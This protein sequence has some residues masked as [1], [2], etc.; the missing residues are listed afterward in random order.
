MHSYAHL[1]LPADSFLF[2]VLAQFPGVACFFV[3]SGFLVSESCLKST[4]GEFFF[5]RAL[6]IYPAL[7]VN[8]IVLEFLLW[9]SGSVV[10]SP[11]TYA[12][13]LPV[14]ILTASEH[15]GISASGGPIYAP[16]QFFT[17]YPSGVLWTLTVELSFYLILPLVLLPVKQIGRS[18]GTAILA[19][20]AAGSFAMAHSADAAFYAS[21]PKLNITIAPYFW[22]FALGVIVRLWWDSL[23]KFFVGRAFWWLAGY[24][25]LTVTAINMGADSW[26]DYKLGPGFD[27][28]SRLVVMGCATLSC[29]YTLPSLAQRLGLA[30]NDYSYGLYLW[31]MLVVATLIALGF[32]GQWWLWPVVYAGGL[33]LAATS[34]HVIERPALRLKRSTEHSRSPASGIGSTR[35]L[36]YQSR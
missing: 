9:L 30:K 26:L 21:N 7:A 28:L 5:K 14:Y 31:H 18:A 19:L 22:L 23:A 36:D 35:R 10:A 11:A 6:R 4:T 12:K 27:A 8:I 17:M 3:I 2:R 20:L 32:D 34:W 1:H 16:W 24:G 33:A 25:L 29:A 13:F 15:F